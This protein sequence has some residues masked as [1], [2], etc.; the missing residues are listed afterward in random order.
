MIIRFLVTRNYNGDD[1]RDSFFRDWEAMMDGIGSPGEHQELIENLL[2][3]YAHIFP[4]H[5]FN[6]QEV[7]EKFVVPLTGWWRPMGPMQTFDSMV[8]FHFLV[9]C[10]IA[11]RL[12]ANHSSKKLA[13]EIKLL[14]ESISDVESSDLTS[15]FDVINSKLVAHERATRINR[16]EHLP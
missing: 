1:W 6:L 15:H 7:C 13:M 12:N 11:K 3:L 2:K 5:E 10:N 16:G 9:K 14:V 4:D 8:S